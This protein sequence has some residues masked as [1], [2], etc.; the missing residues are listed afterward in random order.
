LLRLACDNHSPVTGYRALEAV[1]RSALVR[2]ATM[3]LRC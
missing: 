1:T 2:I 3:P